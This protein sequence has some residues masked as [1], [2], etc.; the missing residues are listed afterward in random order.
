MRGH[1]LTSLEAD[2]SKSVDRRLLTRSITTKA[3][4]M[5]RQ[6]QPEALRSNQKQAATPAKSTKGQ[7]ESAMNSHKQPQAVGSGR[8]HQEATKTKQKQQRAARST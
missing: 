5:D 1:M 7:P 4:Y 2:L 6:D 8:E 3:T